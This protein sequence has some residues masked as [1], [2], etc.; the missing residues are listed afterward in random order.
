MWLRNT[1]QG[2][3]VVSGAVTWIVQ[4]TH[5]PWNIARHLLD[6]LKICF[7][8]QLHRILDLS[9]KMQQKFL[10]GNLYRG[11]TASPNRGHISK[12]YL[13]NKK[14]PL[15]SILVVSWYKSI[16][17]R[18]ERRLS[19]RK[20][21]VRDKIR[22]SVETVVSFRYKFKIKKKSLSLNS[23]IG[24]DVHFQDWASVITFLA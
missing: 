4:K 5:Q 10:P 14:L 23:L 11:T 13:Q 1:L 8:D 3:I 9:E 7:L 15:S 6:F 21:S 22:N 2:L 16:P 19:T 18:E 17:I 24:N 20:P 12:Q